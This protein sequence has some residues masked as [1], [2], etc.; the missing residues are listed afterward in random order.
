M[1]PE[2][3]KAWDAPKER[4]R[5]ART[6]DT[7]TSSGHSNPVG[8]VRLSRVAVTLGIV[9]AIAAL[10]AGTLVLHRSVNPKDAAPATYAAGRYSFVA[11][12]PTAPMVTSVRARFD[13]KPYTETMYAASDGST[14]SSV[15]VFPF[16]IGSPRTSAFT[17]LRRFVAR[18]HAG[19]RGGSLRAG[20]TTM[21]QGLPSLWL[22]DAFDGGNTAF[23]GVIV[24]DG[25]VAYELIEMGPA[26]T[27]NMDFGH[28]PKDPSVRGWSAST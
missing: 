6:Q 10:A 3:L 20:R 11:A 25:H 18:N 7:W 4:V 23:F 21:V 27:V 26:T 1:P 14:Y 24:L 5:P 15:R 12:F 13:G 9:I 28:R 19:P 17:F 8:G 16:P 22:A 2:L